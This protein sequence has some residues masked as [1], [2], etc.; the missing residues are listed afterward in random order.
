[1]HAILHFLDVHND[2]VMGLFALLMML[3]FAWIAHQEYK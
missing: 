2:E 3:A 1:M